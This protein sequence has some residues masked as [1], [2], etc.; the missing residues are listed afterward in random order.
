MQMGQ[1]DAEHGILGQ[2]E[3]NYDLLE[4]SWSS[5][6]GSNRDV[7]VCDHEGPDDFEPKNKMAQLLREEYQTR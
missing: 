6:G 7:Q 5:F 1:D 2:R 3:R 4:Q